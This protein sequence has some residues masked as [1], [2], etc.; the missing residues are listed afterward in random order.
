MTGTDRYD[1]RNYHLCI[2]ANAAGF[3]TAQQMI[4]GL[5]EK[6]QQEKGQ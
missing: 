6:M 3:E 2:D 1:A 5:V 4:I